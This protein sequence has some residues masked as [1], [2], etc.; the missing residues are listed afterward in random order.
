[1]ARIQIKSLAKGKPP[2][3]DSREKNYTMG[4]NLEDLDK[5][6][7]EVIGGKDIGEDEDEGDEDGTVAVEGRTSK[8][9]RTQEGSG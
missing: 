4:V 1:M 7:K 3:P 9:R 2:F 5:P 8:R 6:G